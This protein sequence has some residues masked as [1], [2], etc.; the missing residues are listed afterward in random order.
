M[1]Q[2]MRKGTIIIVQST[3]FCAVFQAVTIPRP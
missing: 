1:W 2:D 3:I